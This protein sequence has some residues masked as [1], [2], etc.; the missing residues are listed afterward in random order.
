MF[1]VHRREKSGNMLLAA[2]IELD[3]SLCNNAEKCFETSPS[4]T[5][6]WILLAPGSCYLKHLARVCGILN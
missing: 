5:E 4:T 6:T 2:P 1:Q 3:G